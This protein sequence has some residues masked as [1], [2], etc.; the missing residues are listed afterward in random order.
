MLSIV[1]AHYLPSNV[2]KR[3][4]LIIVKH[5]NATL[6]KRKAYLVSFYITHYVGP[7]YIK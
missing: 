1:L 4:I 3:Y 5:N 2:K 7:G 6:Y